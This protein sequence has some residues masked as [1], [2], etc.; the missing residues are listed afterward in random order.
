MPNGRRSFSLAI[1]SASCLLRMSIVVK[2]D[3]I[4]ST[5]QDLGRVGY[6]RFGINPGGVMDHNT[7]R[8]LNYL[9]GN[10]P[11]AAVIEIHFPAGSFEFEVNCQFAIGGADF[12]A[13]LN[14]DAIKT[15]TV[16]TAKM[17]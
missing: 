13:R 9:L 4:L 10:E 7:T 15:G 11:N 17:G 2:K 5:V 1:S 14:G 12:G 3:G 8:G 6:R 16:V